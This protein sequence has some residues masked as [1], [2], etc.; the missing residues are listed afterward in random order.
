MTKL[1]QFLRELGCVVE[2]HRFLL[3]FGTGHDRDRMY[4]RCDACGKRTV[5]IRCGERYSR[6]AQRAE[7]QRQWW[8]EVNAGKVDR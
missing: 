8:R 5:G 6:L 7:S 1:R 4:L 2:G 3:C